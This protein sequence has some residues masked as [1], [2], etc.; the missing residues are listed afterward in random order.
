MLLKTAVAESFLKL[1]YHEIADLKIGHSNK[2]NLFILRIESNRFTYETLVQQLYDLIITFALSRTETERLKE[3]PGQK[4]K[5]A[6]EKLRNHFS[7]EGE[8][9]E[10]L[11]YSFLEAHLKAPKLLTKLELKTSPNDYVKGADGVHLLKLGTNNFQIV[12]GESKLY[13]NLDSGIDE[14]FKSIREFLD[15]KKNKIGYEANLLTSQLL[16]ESVDEETYKYLRSIIIPTERE[17]DIELDNSFGIFLGFEHEC[18]EEEKRLDNNAF[19]DLVKNRIKTIANEAMIKI[20]KKMN[21]SSLTG[22]NFYVYLMPFT[23]LELTRKEII[24]KITV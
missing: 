22:Y 5:L 18:S 19:R 11:L 24:K 8:L 23:E 17:E 13:S 10:V 9:G 6:C 15:L 12:F 20:E 2:L 16:K 14:A 3:S 1:F 4:Y 7:N 21:D